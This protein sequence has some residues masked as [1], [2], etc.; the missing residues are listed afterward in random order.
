MALF[1]HPHC[2]SFI[3]LSVC[4]R[5]LIVLVNCD[6]YKIQWIH[7]YRSSTSLGQSVLRWNQLWPQSDHD[8]EPVTRKDSIV[9]MVLKN[10][11]LVFCLFVS[12]PRKTVKDRTE[13]G[14]Q[15]CNRYRTILVLYLNVIAFVRFFQPIQSTCINSRPHNSFASASDFDREGR[16]FELWTTRVLRCKILNTNS[17]SGD[18]L[19]YT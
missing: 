9:D 13:K 17:S 10:T 12:K 1:P 4:T 6:V 3:S 19:R 8:T 7:S 2:L 18:V 5:T 11:I 16:K 15:W 14:G